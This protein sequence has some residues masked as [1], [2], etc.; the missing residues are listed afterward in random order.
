[1]KESTAFEPQTIGYK[2]GNSAFQKSP[3]LLLFGQTVDPI[4]L[5][6][7]GG[8]WDL[9]PTS[10]MSTGLREAFSLRGIE[11]GDGGT[12]A[13]KQMINDRLQPHI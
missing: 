1:M 7:K 5:I 4:Q 2:C 11:R 12:E 6:A 8:G 9:P 10:T 3:P 13:Q